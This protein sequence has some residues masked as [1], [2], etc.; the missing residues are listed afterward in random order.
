MR[1]SPAST[2]WTMAGIRPSDVHFREARKGSGS[3]RLTGSGLAVRDDNTMW[4]LDVLGG[5][6]PHPTLLHEGGGLDLA[7]PSPRGGG[8]GGG[9]FGGSRPDCHCASA[10]K[11]TPGNHRSDA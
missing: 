1:T 4:L 11:D 8:R 6:F 10:L 9:P 3:A 7:S 2:S 5:R